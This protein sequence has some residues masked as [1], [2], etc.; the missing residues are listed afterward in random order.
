MHLSI[1]ASLIVAAYIPLVQ[2]LLVASSS[3]SWHR[4]S[5]AADHRRRG[6]SSRS[7]AALTMNLAGGGLNPLSTPDVTGDESQEEFVSVKRHEAF[8]KKMGTLPLGFSVGISELTFDPVE[9]PSM[10]DLPM[11]LTLIM[12][13]KPTTAWTALYTTNAFPGA[14]VLVGKRRLAKG[15]PLQA[16]IVNNKIANVCAGGAPGAGEKASEDICRGVGRL[17]SLMRE[18]EGGAANDAAEEEE[19]YAQMVLPCSTGVI[20]WSLPVPAM[21]R[22]V[23]TVVESARSGSLNAL[24]AARGIMTTDRYPK[25]R[26][27]WRLLL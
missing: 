24:D 6:G 7:R 13:D 8:L 16:I 27:T 5:F 17:L 23:P 22:A 15:G 14:P 2:G 1:R 26:L 4:G 19:A 25:V 12:L 11:R 10:V 18:E 9:V 20:G 21:L 3:A